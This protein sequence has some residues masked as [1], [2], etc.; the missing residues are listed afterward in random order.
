MVQLEQVTSHLKDFRIRSGAPDVF[1]GTVRIAQ[2]GCLAWAVPR[3]MAFHPNADGYALYDP[4]E[5]HAA[6]RGASAAVLVA[7]AIFRGTKISGTEAHH[8]HAGSA[9]GMRERALPE[10]GRMLGTRHGHIHDFGRYLHA[11]VRI[12]RGAER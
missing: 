6:A 10:H 5:F 8:A 12:L 3:T 2:P 11:G 4:S 1:M 7:C 9:Y